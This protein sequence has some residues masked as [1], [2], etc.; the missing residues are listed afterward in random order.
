M[1]EYADLSR[2]ELW[3]VGSYPQELAGLPW[4]WIRSSKFPIPSSNP[5]GW[6]MSLAEPRS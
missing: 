4:A 1:Q 3:S 2:L 6:F 5:P